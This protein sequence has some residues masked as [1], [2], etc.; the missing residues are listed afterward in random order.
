LKVCLIA[1]TYLPSRRAN[2]I[3]VMKMAQAI[4]L[5]GHTVR[6]LVPHSEKPVGVASW[7][8]L[9]HHYGLQQP[10]DVEWLP[11]NA[12]LRSY[13][14]G[15]KS[16]LRAQRWGA[17][18]IYTRLPQAAALGSFAGV[19]TIFEIHDLPRGMLGPWLLTRFLRGK[20]ARR[21]V[22]ITKALRADLP[23]GEFPAIIAPDG[24][25]LERYLDL[26]APASARQRLSLPQQFT[27]G[28]SGHLYAG[29]GV[30]VLLALAER[31]PDMTFLLVGGNPGDVEKA[32]Q[33]AQSQG[34]DNLVL[35]GFVP[36]SELPQYQAACDVLLMPYQQ[37]VA[38]SSG[39]DIA[40]YLS[41]M[42]LFEYM[43][44][45]RP[46]VSS[47]LPVLSET[48]NAENAILL[49]PDDI[50]AWVEALHNLRANPARRAALGIQARQD[51]QGYSWTARARNIL[52]D[53]EM[54]E[55]FRN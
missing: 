15:L 30:D 44:C 36:N 52:Q 42:K 23:L 45:G 43:A 53:M 46:I 39:G 47:D 32:R 7:D 41:P 33:Q 51:A 3:Q 29:R 19:H 35:T 26:P 17:D 11:V 55:H 24:V 1:P 16:V 13:D 2:T 10:F 34:M 18:L 27:V 22:V 50:D 49:P 21:L 12:R 8:D 40:R 25:D 28:Y 48:L 31:L 5:L 20:G 37:Q 9:A 38:A 4:S 14:Y 54:S 6:V